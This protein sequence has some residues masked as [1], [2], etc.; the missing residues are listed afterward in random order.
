MPMS[1][2]VL[3]SFNNVLSCDE[4][5]M[6]FANFRQNRICIGLAC[7]CS[8][9]VNISLYRQYS[10]KVNY[11]ALKLTTTKSVDRPNNIVCFM[12]NVN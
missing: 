4:N 11:M 7:P 12:V 10:R 5:E 3:F 2:A 6:K 8:F 9:S 1:P